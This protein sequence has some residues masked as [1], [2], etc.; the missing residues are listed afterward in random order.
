MADTLNHTNIPLTQDTV[1]INPMEIPQRQPLGEQFSGV[2][3]DVDGKQLL[4]LMPLPDTETIARGNFVVRYGLRYIGRSHLSIVPGIVVLDYGDMLTGEDA[5]TF[6]LKRSNLHP[7]AEVVGY[8]NDGT[9]DIVMVRN[10]DMALPV[11]VL[12]YADEST[13][14]PAYRPEALI[15]LDEDLPPYL[16]EYLPRFN[17]LEEWKITLDV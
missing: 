2:V 1:H 9:D 10:L 6:L 15:T 8:R 7:R 16:F 13:I 17:S 12:V 14:I 4:A 3:A 5:W 11:E